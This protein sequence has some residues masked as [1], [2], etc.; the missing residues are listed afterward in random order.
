[1]QTARSGPSS[2]RGL[3][4][5]QRGV[6]GRLRLGGDATCRKAA[7]DLPWGH[8]QGGP[9]GGT[10]RAAAADQQGHSHPGPDNATMQELSLNNKVLVLG[11]SESPPI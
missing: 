11:R 6:A 7:K 10:Y 2:I 1:M 5:S 9:R 8:L 3:P 4:R